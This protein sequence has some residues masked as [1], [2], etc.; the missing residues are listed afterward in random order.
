[1]AIEALPAADRVTA[2]FTC[3]TRKEAYIKARGAG[4]S[5]PLTDFDVSLRPGEPAEILR[6]AE[7]PD[8][9]RRWAV[10]PVDVPAVFVASLVVE[11]PLGR[12]WAAGRS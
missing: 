7:G 11:A 4:L 10:V 5:Y 6:S 8:E 12:V 3:W 1:M 9:L 2:F